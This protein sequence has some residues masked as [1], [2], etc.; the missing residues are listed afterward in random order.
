MK[1]LRSLWPAGLVLALAAAVPIFRLHFFHTA[2][3]PIGLW[4][5]FP[6][7]EPRVGEVVR[8]CMRPEQA[9]ETTGRPY[10]GGRAGG[11]C[12]HY[13]WSLAKPVVAGPGDTILHSAEAVWVNGHREPLSATRTRDSRGLPVPTAR[14][15]RFVLGSGEYWVLSPYADGSFDSRY[16]G[17]IR[18]DQMLGTLRPV[19][20]WLT[21]S[22]RAALRARGFGPARCGLVTCMPQPKGRAPAARAAS[23]CAAE[24]VID[25]DTLWCGGRRIRL[26]GDRRP[27]DGSD[28][29]RPAGAR[30]AGTTRSTCTGDQP[31]SPTRRSACAR[32]KP[33][34]DL[35]TVART[36]HARSSSREAAANAPPPHTR[37]RRRDPSARLVV[38]TSTG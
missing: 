18:R 27:R 21:G 28:A 13:T 19:I 30:G 15:G 1:R 2:S 6:S 16:L 3:A 32:G 24:E 17:V 7:A 8:F 5:A 10:A 4:R 12:P 29:V 25:G 38:L 22:Q 11:P 20:T 14:E 37:P 9:R 26:I 35:V 34:A 36:R 33:S 23:T 31:L